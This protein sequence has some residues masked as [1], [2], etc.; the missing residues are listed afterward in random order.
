MTDK[1]SVNNITIIT[2][3]LIILFAGLFLTIHSFAAEGVEVSTPSNFILYSTG[4]SNNTTASGTNGHWNTW[5]PGNNVWYDEYGV[6]QYQIVATGETFTGPNDLLGNPLFAPVAAAGTSNFYGTT[7]ASTSSNLLGGSREYM[8]DNFNGNFSADASGLTTSYI[9]IHD[10]KFASGKTAT[11]TANNGTVMEMYDNNFNGSTTIN[12]ASGGTVNVQIG[13]STEMQ[14]LLS[15][16]SQ[17]NTLLG[18]TNTLLGNLLYPVAIIWDNVIYNML[19]TTQS[20]SFTLFGQTYSYNGSASY[21]ADKVYYTNLRGTLE[22]YLRNLL[23]QLDYLWTETY[24]E[25]DPLRKVFTIDRYPVAL[26]R[27]AISVYS[28]DA[29][30]DVVSV[31]NVY[32]YKTYVGMLYE[33]V[34]WTIPSYFTSMIQY[35]ADTWYRWYNPNISLANSKFWKAYNT[36]TGQYDSVNFSTVFMYITWYLGQIYDDSTNVTNTMH[37][38]TSDIG[39]A[40]TTFQDLNNKEQVAI[41]QIQQGFE[42]FLPDVTQFQSFRAITWCSNYLQQIYIALGAYG[43]VIFI[44]LLFGVC[45]QFIGYF[46]YK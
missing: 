5:D 27:V 3:L 18:T 17:T 29:S 12:A 42:T 10:S 33:C 16:T 32:R 45:L 1:R 31:E 35:L 38:M 23:H 43:Q 19:S 8:G 6:P 9:D 37:Q 13:N 25:G 11:V 20:R 41:N 46:R 2:Y 14:Q 36:D 4:G 34:T 15:N 44:A 26:N 22:L 24:N 40:A 28:Y 30:T 21:L 7:T 39:T